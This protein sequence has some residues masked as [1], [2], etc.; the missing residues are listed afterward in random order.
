MAATNGPQYQTS[1]EVN[2]RVAIVTL[3]GEIDIYARQAL[4][5]RLAELKRSAPTVVVL[6]LQRVSFFSAEGANWLIQV[7]R[8]LPGAQMVLAES[9]PVT[10]IIEAC[11]LRRFLPKGRQTD[12]RGI[13]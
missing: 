9:Q 5:E 4:A 10:R 13:H 6:R 8:E 1:L 12:S 3:A 2:G 11:R 7:K